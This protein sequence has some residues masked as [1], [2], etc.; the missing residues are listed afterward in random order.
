MAPLSS[1]YAI[2]GDVV[3]CRSGPG[4]SF[5]VVRTYKK[6]QDVSLTCQT[7][8]TSVNG[9]AL[10]DKTTDGCFVADYYVSTGTGNYVTGR[11]EG[12]SSP[13]SEG[14][15]NGYCK[16]VNQ[17]G[18]DLIS[19]WEGFV[20]SPRPDPVGLPTVG[21]GHL[22]QQKNCAEVHYS[23]PLSVATAQQLLNDD[24]PKYSSCLA[25]Y[26][27][28]RVTL[29]DNQWAALVSWVFNNGCG[30]AKSSTLVQRLNNGEDPSTVASQE[31]P[32]WR[33]AGGHVLQGLVNRRADEVRLF[34]TASS[35][36]AY[37]NCR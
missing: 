11:C 26:L 37:P 17:A 27:N 16:K 4:T 1:A 24:V 35:K 23:F 5:S 22:C 15:G 30:S 28:N 21:Y 14:N 20:A 10:W 33:M 9:D 19:R 36:Q 6:G 8:G 18:L 34:K 2:N 32:Q 3:N 29:N 13:P 25:S 31:L 7:V 12:G